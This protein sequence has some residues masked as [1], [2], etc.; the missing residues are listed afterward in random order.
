M[1]FSCSVRLSGIC[2]LACPRSHSYSPRPLRCSCASLSQM[3]CRC[4]PRLAREA[5]SSCQTISTQVQAIP[6]MILQFELAGWTKCLRK[7][8]AWE[9]KLW[10]WSIHPDTE[11]RFLKTLNAANSCG[12]SLQ[13]GQRSGMIGSERRMP[14]CAVNTSVCSLM[15]CIMPCKQLKRG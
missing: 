5:C 8:F 12:Q 1:H 3:P 10:A 14:I 4:R 2:M 6:D 15:R 9:R 11:L 13:I 7:L